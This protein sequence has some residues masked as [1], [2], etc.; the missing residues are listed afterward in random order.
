MFICTPL[1]E[2]K[3]QLCINMWPLE[4]NVNSFYETNMTWH[5]LSAKMVVI[6]L[7]IKCNISDYVSYK[8]VI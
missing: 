1:K 8:I 5:F 6:M 4:D 7:I 2:K 3:K